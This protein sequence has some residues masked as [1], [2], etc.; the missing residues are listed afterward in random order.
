MHLKSKTRRAALSACVSSLLILIQGVAPVVH[1]AGIGDS[2][3]AGLPRVDGRACAVALQ[4]GHDSTADRDQAAHNP[5]HCL[6]CR[7]VS[8]VDGQ[9]S[10]LASV[11]V[12]SVPSASRF[13]SR[14][15]VFVPSLAPTRSLSL[16][17]PPI[18]SA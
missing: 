7:S 1:M 2:C 5:L 16:R 3:I 13:L 18:L 15:D 14:D 9:A 11:G 10:L 4:T 6:L 12:V 17:A 8:R